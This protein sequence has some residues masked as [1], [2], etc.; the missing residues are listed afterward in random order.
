VQPG[1]DVHCVRLSAL[2][3]VS[4]PPQV[5]VPPVQLQPGWFVL[6]QWLTS[7]CPHGV[8]VPRHELVDEYEHSGECELHPV[9]LLLNWL[10][11]VTVP[12]HVDVTKQPR[13]VGQVV[14]VNEVH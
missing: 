6:V 4:D 11:A 10:Q 3:D 12:L 13:A 14:E 2:H 5:M 9:G 1:T 7:S 8:G